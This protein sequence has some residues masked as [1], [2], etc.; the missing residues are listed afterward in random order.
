MLKNILL[1]FNEELALGVA[2]TKTSACLGA[3]YHEVVQTVP[4]IVR[5]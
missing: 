5:Q 3:K 4:F 1:A 2:W